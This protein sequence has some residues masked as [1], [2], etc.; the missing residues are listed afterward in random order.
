MIAEDRAKEIAAEQMVVPGPLPDQP[1][2]NAKA[3][4]KQ[5]YGNTQKRFLPGTEDTTVL[6]RVHKFLEEWL[7]DMLADPEW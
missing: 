3:T 5:L 6:T 1:Q 7:M 2:R 4:W